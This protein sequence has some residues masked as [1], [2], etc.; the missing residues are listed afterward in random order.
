LGSVLGKM[1]LIFLLLGPISVTSRA[2]SLV[3]SKTIQSPPNA[4]FHA[5]EKPSFHELGG[6]LKNTNE[7][8]Q[9]YK[10]TQNYTQAPASQFPSAQLKTLWKSNE[11]VMQAWLKENRAS[12]PFSRGEIDDEPVL[13]EVLVAVQLSIL[14]AR[15]KALR[16]QFDLAKEDLAPWFTMAADMPYEEASLISLRLANVIRSLLFDEVERMEKKWSSIIAKNQSWLEWANSIRLSWPIDRVV[17]SE[18]RKLLTNK[19]MFTAQQVAL[20]LQK[21]AY[22]TAAIALKQAQGPKTPELKFLEKMWRQ[23]DIDAMKTEV[24]RLSALRIRLAAEIYQNKYKETPP[25]IESLVQ[26]NLLSSIPLD[27]SSGKPF[28]LEQAAL[29]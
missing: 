9:L 19:P 15:E 18:S 12:T 24:H 29:H 14:Q 26:K 13:N 23:E 2:A 5:T 10:A 20:A 28:T 17:I 4:T 3:D 8:T 27:Y 6:R 21:N 7:I 22:Q 25:K 16:Q 1:G 11:A